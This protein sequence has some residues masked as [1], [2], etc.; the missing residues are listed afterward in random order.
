MYVI[1]INTKYGRSYWS[2]TEK[3]FG[4]KQ[5]TTKYNTYE[6]AA[7]STCNI[8]EYKCRNYQDGYIRIE[9]DGTP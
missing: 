6:E 9:E 1:Y 5:L 7:V 2:D 8:Q 3:M 4:V